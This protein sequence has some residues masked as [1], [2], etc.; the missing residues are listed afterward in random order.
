MTRSVDRRG[1]GL[2]ALSSASG[3]PGPPHDPSTIGHL[4]SA[5]ASPPLEDF[6]QALD[7]YRTSSWLD[8]G[9]SGGGAFPSVNVSEKTTTSSS[10]SSFRG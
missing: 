2:I 3:R 6:Q 5:A 1:S 10:S 4:R 8:A 9:L 7:A